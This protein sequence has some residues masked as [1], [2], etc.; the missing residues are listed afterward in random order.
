MGS[1]GNG[2]G[3]GGGKNDGR[4]DPTTGDRFFVE[5]DGIGVMRFKEATGLTMRTQ[6]RTVREGGNNRYERILYEGQSFEPLRIK[7]GF[8]AASSELFDWMA[9]LHGNGPVVRRTIAIVVLNETAE[10]VCRFEL[11]GAHIV[12][13]E[14][15]QFDGQERQV[16]FESITIKYEY[17]ELHNGDGVH[18]I[19]LSGPTL[20][21]AAS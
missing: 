10:E 20:A 17:F 1:N 4:L 16:C 21:A 15:P 2:N 18:P 5:M 7:K 9:S 6:T 3:S 13:Y 8:Y 14:G 19:G 12:E 11:F